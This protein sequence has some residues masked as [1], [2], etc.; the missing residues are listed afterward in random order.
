MKKT[1]FLFKTELNPAECKTKLQEAIQEEHIPFL[2]FP[3][4]NSKHMVLGKLKE[5]AFRLRKHNFVQN[6]FAPLF[7]GEIQTE[8][9]K[10]VIAGQ[11]KMLLVFKIFLGFWVGIIL[12]GGVF[13]ST[14]GIMD[15]L[16]GSTHITQGDPLVAA[17]MGPVFA[18]VMCALF[19]FFKK[20]GEKDKVFLISFLE[21]LFDTQHQE[22]K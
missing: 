7:Y 21:K 11:F 8:K 17:F 14:L 13:I 2:S 4:K 1:K 16:T 3:K 15:L 18:V 5:H 12:F 6:S 20:W 22:I 9:G 19:W 10:A